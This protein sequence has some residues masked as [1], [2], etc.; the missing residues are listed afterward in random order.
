M[1][2]KSVT[3][4]DL[5][6]EAMDIADRADF[7]KRKGEIALSLKLFKEA[8]EKEKEAAMELEE[9][10]NCEPTRSVLFRSAGWLAYNAEMFK[11]ALDMAI[12]GKRFCIHSDIKSELED[13]YEAAKAKK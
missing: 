1:A 4:R 5:H 9:N 10:V 8:F 3:S 2:D 13:L 12:R 6:A 7:K 11:E